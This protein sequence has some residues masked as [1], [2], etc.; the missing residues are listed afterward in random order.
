MP[1]PCSWCGGSTS[2]MEGIYLEMLYP[3]QSWCDGCG[4]RTLLCTCLT[5]EEMARQLASDP[6]FEAWALER[7]MVMERVA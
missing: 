2:P 3:G 5:R 4:H 7:R 6:E 1:E